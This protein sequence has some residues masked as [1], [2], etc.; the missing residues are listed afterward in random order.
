[1]TQLVHVSPC[2]LWTQQGNTWMLLPGACI[3]F[4]IQQTCLEVLLLGEL[5]ALG[6]TISFYLLC[7][8]C[9]ARGTVPSFSLGSLIPGPALEKGPRKPL[10]LEDDFL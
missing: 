9:A 5:L 6:S 8:P 10:S 3:L 1:V 4:G 2:C 7:L